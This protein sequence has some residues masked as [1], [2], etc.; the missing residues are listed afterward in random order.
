MQVRST[1]QAAQLVAENV[2][3]HFVRQHAA[4][5]ELGE[6]ISVPLPSAAVIQQLLDVCF[7]ASLRR[8]EGHAPK[9]SLAY[10]SPEQAVQPLL[11][12]HRLPFTPNVL[13]KA[14]PGVERAGIH[15]GV[16]QEKGQL[17]IWGTT[18]NVPSLCLVLDVSAPGLLVIKHRRIDG[19]GK[20]KN[21]AIL[22]G[23]Q[24]K[25]VDE[26]VRSTPDCP[27]L[28]N[29]LLG[30]P[31]AL[32]WYDSLHVLVQLAVSMRAHGRGGILLIVPHGTEQWRES[33]VHPLTYSLDP[34]FSAL[35]DL[36]KQ[37]AYAK[38]EARWQIDFRREVDA[39]GG[40]TA[41][42]GATLMSDQYHLLAFG[43]KIMRAHGRESIEKLYSTEPIVGVQAS[44]D[45]PSKSG[46]TRHL[47]AAQF[48]HDQRD[49]LALVAS[50][51][52]RFTIF[53]W[54][55]CEQCVQAHRIDSLL[56]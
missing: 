15:L 16:W 26:E 35:S 53:S 37:P 13:I 11:L 12:R 20:F 28:L 48:V 40:L 43:A 4:A 54:S 42:D 45:H 9:I 49:C 7:W 5:R 34:P 33:I 25:I 24:I 8:E 30:G 56:L 44:I 39:I 46:G 1:Y 6:Q 10:L 21:V 18:R 38:E 27:S 23:D 32:H 2:E 14:S 47:S 55:P 29:R 52:G 22:Q 3:A 36:V 17:Y 51:D 31:N 50:Q 41:I 19:F